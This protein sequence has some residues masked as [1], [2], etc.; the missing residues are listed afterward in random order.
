MRFFRILSSSLLLISLGIALAFC[1]QNQVPNKPSCEILNK[2]GNTLSS[3]FNVPTGFERIAVEKASF[4]EY[5][6]NIPLKLDGSKVKYFDGTEKPSDGVYCAVIDLP[7]GK[8]DIHH[9]ADAVMHLRVEYLF[10]KGDFQNIH[11]NFTNGFKAEYSKW[12]DGYRIKVAGNNCS[13]EKTAKAEN[14]RKVFDKFMEMVYS[15]AGTASLAKELKSVSVSEM[16]IGDV[17]IRGGS[18]G[19]A[20]IVVDMSENKK[21]GEKLFMLA[22]SYMP[23]QEI[24]ILINPNDTKIS[25]WYKTNFPTQLETPQYIFERN[26]LKRFP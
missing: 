15:Y 14:S 10:Q 6:R 26:E 17:F 16:H 3:R 19:H 7:I 8:S 5:L 2:S 21:T 11:F 22:Q 1:T 20:V 23:A 12:M 25:P 18:P 4:A 24:Q 13:W 9:C